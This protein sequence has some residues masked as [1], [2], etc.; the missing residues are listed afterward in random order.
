MAIE[1]LTRDDVVAPESLAAMRTWLADSDLVGA[2]P[3]KGTFGASRGFAITFT[4]DGV[5]E[6]RQRFPVLW[7]FVEVGVL[8]RPWRALYGP[9][10]RFRETRAFYLNVLV[11]PSGAHVARHVDATLSTAVGAAAVTPLAVSVLYLDAPSGGGLKLWRGERQVAEVT[12]AP[13]RFVCFRGDL[14]H[15][16]AAVEGEG[17]RVSVVCEQYAFPRR[18]AALMSAFHVTSRGRFGRILDRLAER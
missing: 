1:L 14:G 16:V 5:A 13:G 9:L 6:L 11:V 10:G 18:R 8:A 3:L 12:P 4:R 7:P 2:S 15:E 17:E